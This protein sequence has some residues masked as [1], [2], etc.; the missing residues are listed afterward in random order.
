MMRGGSLKRKKKDQLYFGLLIIGQSPEIDG[1][2][3]S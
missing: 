1:S 2:K 3:H